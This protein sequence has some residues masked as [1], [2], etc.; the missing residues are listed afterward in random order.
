MYLFF[1][2][3]HRASI[4]V[5]ACGAGQYVRFALRAERV[6]TFAFALGEDGLFVDVKHGFGKVVVL[7]NSKGVKMDLAGSCQYV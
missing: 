7:A 3:L 1:R 4:I 2:Y 6:R 5:V